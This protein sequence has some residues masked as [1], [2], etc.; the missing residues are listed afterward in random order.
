LAVVIAAPTSTCGG[1]FSPELLLG[2]YYVVQ[3]VVCDM[4]DLGFEIVFL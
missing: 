4:I 1:P 2:V 3:V